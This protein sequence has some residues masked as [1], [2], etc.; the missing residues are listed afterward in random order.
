[1]VLWQD[2]S[3][4]LSVKL[5]EVSTQQEAVQTQYQQQSKAN[6]ELSTKLKEQAASIQKLTTELQQQ[7]KANK[8]LGDKTKADADALE[9][10]Q[11]AARQQLAS[12]QEQ[13]V[14]V[15][16]SKDELDR[17]LTQQIKTSQGLEKQ[18]QRLT[19]ANKQLTAEH[20]NSQQQKQT[21]LETLSAQH[22]ALKEEL[23]KQT[24]DN[25]ALAKQVRT[26]VFHYSKINLCP[27]SAS[28]LNSKRAPQIQARTNTNQH[29][30][31]PCR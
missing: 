22:D 4:S 15:T 8:Q 28:E 29:Q 13:L 31:Q 24:A 25:S 27:L 7:Q 9:T 10:S 1:M 19:T 2:A 18:V 12:V 23:Q 14:A 11:N 26:K 17:K 30:H 5:K 20:A 21:E 16:S 3:S 6:E